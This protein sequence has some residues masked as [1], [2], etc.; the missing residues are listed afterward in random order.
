MRCWSVGSGFAGQDKC[1]AIAIG[2]TD[3]LYDA[4]H[5]SNFGSLKIFVGKCWDRKFAKLMI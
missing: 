3:G 2:M 4:E 1:Q 5:P